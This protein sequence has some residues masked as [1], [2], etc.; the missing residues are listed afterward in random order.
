ML[1]H[2]LR[3]SATAAM[4]LSASA[5]AGAETI[6]Y[7][8]TSPVALSS[9]TIHESDASNQ[10]GDGGALPR[11]VASGLTL[12][13]VNRANVA[14]TG[15]TFLLTGG[16]HA[17]RI[18]DRGTFEQGV[19]ILH[20]YDVDDG[21]SDPDDAVVEVTDVDFADGGAWH[22]QVV[23]TVASAPAAQA[24]ATSR[25]TPRAHTAVSEPSDAEMQRLFRHL[26]MSL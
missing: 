18:V 4:L 17:Q 8:T 13:F 6:A 25:A 19:S 24:T 7:G 9:F 2:V 26:G 3:L 15:V 11:Y 14:A 23:N 10:N 12:D 5:I 22:A 20:T 16:K 21:L 1:N